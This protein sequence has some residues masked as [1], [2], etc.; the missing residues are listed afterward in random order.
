MTDGVWRL[1]PGLR[2]VQTYQRA[3][4]GSDIVA[5]LV[6]T[7]VLVPVGMGY[8]QAAGLPAI[9]GLYATILPLLVYALF[10]P[11]QVLVL[12]PDSSLAPIIA[13]TIAPLALGD[14]ARAGDLAAG[15]ALV[16]GTFC[17]AFGVLRLGILT[18][19]LSKPI[20]IGSL[21][22]IALTIFV[23]QMPKLFGFSVDAAGV[24]RRPPAPSSRASPG[25]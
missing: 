3:W 7:A 6:L 23:G 5:G 20:R 9:A 11:S 24:A 12:G 10:G 17:I 4:L 2:V 15:L 21:N 13:A 14:P 16:S 19:L 25:V 18:E 8:S 1:L 22:G